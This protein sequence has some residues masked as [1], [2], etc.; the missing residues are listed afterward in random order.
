M[1]V[2]KLY[3]GSKEIIIHKANPPS[4]V[5]TYAWDASSINLN[6]N[7]DVEGIYRILTTLDPI[8]PASYLIYDI[9]FLNSLSTAMGTGLWFVDFNS[10]FNA[11][12][13]TPQS[14]TMNAHGQIITINWP[15]KIITSKKIDIISGSTVPTINLNGNPATLPIFFNSGDTVDIYYTDFSGPAHS[16]SIHVTV[17][18]SDNRMILSGF[19][20][21]P[22]NTT[23][24]NNA[25]GGSTFHVI[26]FSLS[27]YE[28]IPGGGTISSYF[29]PDLN[30]TIN[31]HYTI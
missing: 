16:V 9:A 23:L 2:I 3:V 1:N 22:G 19:V 31:V 10:V 15:G 12:I 17:N 25:G 13:L 30:L 26:G 4:G 20:Y 21:T 8:D 18:V 14:K 11:G 5:Y 24:V 7:D 6:Y 29:N 27:D 28:N